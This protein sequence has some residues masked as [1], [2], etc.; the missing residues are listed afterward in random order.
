MNK[1][2]SFYAFL[3]ILATFLLASLWEF[4]IE[5]WAQ[6]SDMESLDE[7]ME[8]VL[9]STSFVF[10]ALIVPT[11]LG[12][13]YLKKLEQANSELAETLNALNSS[14]EEANKLR[15]LEDALRAERQK[16]FNM[17]DNLPIAFHLQAPDYSVPYANKIFRERF[18]NPEKRRCHDLMHQ[19]SQPCEVCSTF[20][21]FD[22]KENETSVWKAPD[23]KTYLTL[24]TPFEDIDGS[25]L[26]M[27]MAMDI[28]EQVRAEE[29]LKQAHDNLEIRV[30]ERTIEIQRSNRDLEDF[31]Y[32]ASHDLQEPLRKIIAFGDRLKHSTSHL[33]QKELDYLE[34]MQHAAGRMQ[35]L[36]Q[37]LLQLSKVTIKGRPFQTVNLNQ[38]MDEVLDDLEAGL[39]I[40][41]GVVQFDKLP[42]LEADPS[43]MRQLF[44]NLIGN[45]IK[46]RREEHPPVLNVTCSLRDKEIWEIRIKDN[47]IGFKNEFAEKIFKPFERLH[48]RGKYNGTGIGLAI[49]K[50]I[51]DR[52]HGDIR[53]VSEPNKGTTFVV[54]LPEKQQSG[55]GASSI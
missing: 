9:L 16:F 7:K 24:C 15:D 20:R 31:A 49:C 37:D 14:Q 1:K 53:A 46:Y 3:T 28:S 50:K 10:L 25:P 41:G 54:T 22:T 42:V 45:G 8:L 13:R 52:H 2:H 11:Y 4:R 19:R 35:N 18:G 32:I 23:G 29:A 40:A 36:V 30:N 44:Q 51:V 27:E 48:G 43:Q 39:C 55:N 12:S 21:V 6:G 34:R 5:E 33:G 47:G 26:V 17:L 38:I